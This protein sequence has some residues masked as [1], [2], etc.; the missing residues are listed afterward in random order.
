MDGTL[1]EAH[2]LKMR[3]KMR[4]FSLINQDLE[5]GVVRGKHR[6]EMST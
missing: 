6:R 2:S 4:H 5:I 3:V 1:T